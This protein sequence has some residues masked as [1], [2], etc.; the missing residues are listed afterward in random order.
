METQN[1]PN[2]DAEVDAVQIGHFS[3]QTESDEI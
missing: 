1:N 2:F 3:N